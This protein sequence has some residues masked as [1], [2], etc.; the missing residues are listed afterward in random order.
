MTDHEKLVEVR[1]QLEDLRASLA[2][3]IRSCAGSRNDLTDLHA[4]VSKA[5]QALYG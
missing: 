2:Q 4:R 5:I 1:R 3:R